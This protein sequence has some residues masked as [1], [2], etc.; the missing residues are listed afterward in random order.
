MPAQSG[1]HTA[2]MGTASRISSL[3]GCPRS[4]VPCSK[5]TASSCASAWSVAAYR[6][7]SMNVTAMGESTST[8]A[9]SRHRAHVASNSPRRVPRSKKPSPASSS[10]P[11]RHN[12]ALVR[13]SGAPGHSAASQASLTA[14]RR[15]IPPSPMSFVLYRMTTPA[16]PGKREA[17]NY[18][19]HQPRVKLRARDCRLLAGRPCHAAPATH[20]QRLE[21]LVVEHELR[22]HEPVEEAARGALRAHVVEDIVHAADDEDVALVER[23]EG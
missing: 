11:S 3:M 8:G 10:F 4:M 7:V 13:P 9:G 19:C 20:Q 14:T 6:S 23:Q 16:S 12:P 21:I 2:L 22:A 17:D 18:R 15:S 1:R 5:R